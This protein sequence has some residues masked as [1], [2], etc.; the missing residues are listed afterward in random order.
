MDNKTTYQKAVS[1]II[2]VISLFAVFIH[3]GNY[4]LFT[5]PLSCSGFSGN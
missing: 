5:M 2:L 4:T 3:V 1:G